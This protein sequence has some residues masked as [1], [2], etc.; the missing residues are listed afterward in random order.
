MIKN[1]VVIAILSSL[2]SACGQ[3]PNDKQNEETIINDSTEEASGFDASLSDSRAVALADSVV[4]A[5]GG[6][7]TYN[8]TRY[9]S[10]NFLGVRDLLWD[11]HTG[12]VRIAFPREGSIYKVNVIADTGQV[13]LNNKRIKDSDSLE[14]YIDKAK[15]MWVN[16]SY[17]LIFPFKLKDPG[18]QLTYL[19]RDTT[20]TGAQAEVIALTF[21]NVGFTPQNK[22]LAYI[23]PETYLISQW[24]YFK[25]ASDSVPAISGVW[26]DYKDYDGLLLSSGRG[27][28]KLSN[29]AVANSLDSAAFTF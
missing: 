21:D 15:Q 10:W 29:I 24:D 13:M 16:D 27:E 14:F 22:Y 6:I 8:K 25:K 1:I 17:W 9:I 2:I 5:S 23:N 11:K 4:A 20:N 26:T 18:V 12:L 7:K 28:R 19:G 3:K